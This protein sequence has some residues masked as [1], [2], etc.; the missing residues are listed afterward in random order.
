MSIMS[1]FMTTYYAMLVG[2]SILY[3]VLSFRSKLEW[4]TCNSPW[5]GLSTYP[6]VVEFF[7]DIFFLSV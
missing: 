7:N 1:F 3:F 2:Y 5:A 6:Y 4:S